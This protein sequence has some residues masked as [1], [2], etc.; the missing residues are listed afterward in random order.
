MRFEAALPLAD[1]RAVARDLGEAMARMAVE[2]YVRHRQAIRPSDARPPAPDA[3][4][5]PR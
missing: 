3:P 4:P 2:S 5:T 1:R